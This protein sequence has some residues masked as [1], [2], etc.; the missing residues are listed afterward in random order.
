[1]ALGQHPLRR[2]VLERLAVEA[3]GFA[4]GVV[5]R[6]QRKTEGKEEAR[7]HISAPPA[8]HAGGGGREAPCMAG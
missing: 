2:G 1:M 3:D 6:H 4:E 8:G 5:E 7:Q